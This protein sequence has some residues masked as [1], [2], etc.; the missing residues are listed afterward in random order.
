M[1]K[2]K[3]ILEI[4]EE[5]NDWEKHIKEEEYQEFYENIECLY[6]KYKSN[7]DVKKY[8]EEKI[9]YDIYC[10]FITIRSFSF[11]DVYIEFTCLYEFFSKEDIVKVEYEF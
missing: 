6:E 7:K 11:G 5:H 1:S 2:Y 8:D 10:D 9:D 3:E 4:I